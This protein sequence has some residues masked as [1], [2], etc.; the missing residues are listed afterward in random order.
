MPQDT[1]AAARR[2]A[3]HA[4]A[5]RLLD[6]CRQAVQLQALDGLDWAA[7]AQAPDWLALPAEERRGLAV[8]LGAWSVVPALAHC[9]D[10]QVFARLREALGDTHFE[11]LMRA[12]AQAER[13]RFAQAD[14]TRA[15]LPGSDARSFELEGLTIWLRAVASSAESADPA[16][17]N[18]AWAALMPVWF[19]PGQEVLPTGFSDAQAR[20]WLQEVRA[21]RAAPM[22]ADAAATDAVSADTEAEAAP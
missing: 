14:T 5:R 19:F 10:G 3:R 22:P 21:Q 16:E 7:L 20:A 4:H 18:P 11:A 13:E 6:E 9:I 1:S 15:E 8:H 12:T 17:T 2:Q